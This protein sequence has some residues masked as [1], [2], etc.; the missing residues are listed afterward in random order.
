MRSK[1]ALLLLMVSALSVTQC[2]HDESGLFPSFLTSVSHRRQLG[3]YFQRVDGGTYFFYAMR[4]PAVNSEYVYLI[5]ALPDGSR[6]LAVF[7]A[8][9]DPVAADDSPDLGAM[10]MLLDNFHH[11][12]GVR[13]FEFPSLPALFTTQPDFTAIGTCRDYQMVR[14]MSGGP[15]PSPLPTTLTYYTL[16]STFTG[17]MTHL[18]YWRF[19]Y[20]SSAL[21]YSGTSGYLAVSGANRNL[22]LE[23]AGN[24]N[25][26]SLYLVLRDTSTDE[27]F[28][29]AFPSGTTFPPPLLTFSSLAPLGR[30]VAGSAQIA[31]NGFVVART[32]DGY[33]RRY[34]MNGSSEREIL[35]VT[36]KEFIIA[37]G[38]DE[39]MYL[40]N[41]STLEL[42]KSRAWWMNN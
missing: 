17:L 29:L 41:P 39:V 27:A 21:S 20:A 16:R 42:F 22:A 4:A 6:R 30:I 10:H 19:D 28:F 26:D 7:N 25:G 14:R 12:T 15:S 8:V 23:T 37:Y 32:Y 33:I 11:L 36:F 34:N 38:Q 18:E 5:Q 1:T 13:I 35:G 24:D 9:L 2:D 31:P 40:F 3:D